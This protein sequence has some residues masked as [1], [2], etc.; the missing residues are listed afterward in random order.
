MLPE[1]GVII[2]III[3][4]DF[5]LLKVR[6]VPVQFVRIILLK[7]TLLYFMMSGVTEKISK[8]RLVIVGY[9]AAGSQVAAQLSKKNKYDV[10]VVTPFNYMEVSL[11]MTRALAAGGKDYDRCVFPLLAENNVEYVMEACTSIVNGVVTVA[12][13]RRLEFDVCI[14]ASGQRIPIFYPDISETTLA[15][16]KTAVDKIHSDILAADSICIAGAGPVGAEF[17]ADLKLRHKS[18][19]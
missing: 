8:K 18:K 14:V 4:D 17:A 2:R 1:T 3:C 5:L 19:K 12:S 10:T 11:N 9:G 6:F 7:F 15:A 16:R 13:G